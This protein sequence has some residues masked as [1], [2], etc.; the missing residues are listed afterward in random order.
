MRGVLCSGNLVTDLL[1][2]PVDRLAWG[3]AT[4]VESI[5]QHLGGNGSNTSYALGKLGI[6]VRVLGMVGNDAFGDYVLAQ[7]GGAG[8]DTSAVRR[9]S[10]P[11]ATSVAL[12]KSD[13][14]RLFLH[15]LGASREVDFTAAE[16]AHE[17]AGGAAFYHLASPFGLP[18]LRQRQPEIMRQA[19]EAGLTTSIDTHWDSA[20]RWLADLAPSLPFTR[21]LFVNQD[22]ARMLAGTDVHEDSART[23]RRCGAQAIVVKMGRNG[24]A[25]FRDEGRFHTPAFEVPVV[26]TTGAGDCFVGGFLSALARGCSW[27]DAALYANAVGALSVQQ[28]GGVE[29]VLA[30][31]ETARWIGDQRPAPL[32][33]SI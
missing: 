22:E 13:G 18:R 31:D 15:R 8:V 23:L 7:L 17:F 2:R 11:T 19:R 33:R 27:E 12:V 21:I 32:A 10:A 30:W 26:D 4:L 6:P 20:G 14:D 24:C 3:A 28:L 9:S 16:L 29:G 25:V 5:E 1:V